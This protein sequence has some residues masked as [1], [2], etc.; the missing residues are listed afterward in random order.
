MRLRVQFRYRADT[1]EVEIF[2]VE[3]VPEGPRLPD[4]DA[5][6]DRAARALARIVDPHALVVEE[7]PAATAESVPEERQAAPADEEDEETATP[8]GPIRERPQR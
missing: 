4:H 8:Q 7:D 2:Q 1:G 6:H 5:R 3:D